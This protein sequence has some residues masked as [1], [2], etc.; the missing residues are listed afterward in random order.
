[1]KPSHFPG[2]KSLINPEYSILKRQDEHV[3]KEKSLQVWFIPI[4]SHG[5]VLL[6]PK[7]H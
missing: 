3:G 7:K 6:S 2:I 5:L 4:A 1:M